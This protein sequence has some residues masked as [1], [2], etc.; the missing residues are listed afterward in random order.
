[1]RACA[2]VIVHVGAEQVAQMSLAEHHDM[3]K[4]FAPESNRS[5]VQ[6]VHSAMAIATPLAGHAC[7]SSERVG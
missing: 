5:A 6:H 7:P 2:V 1:M 4:T 3:I